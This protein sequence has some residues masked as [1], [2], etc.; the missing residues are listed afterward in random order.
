MEGQKVEGGLGG[1]R[2]GWVNGRTD[3]GMNQRKDGRMLER[4]RDEEMNGWMEGVN[5]GKAIHH[6]NN[7]G[8]TANT[9]HALG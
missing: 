5:G 7:T 1:S 3:G 9:L 6:P 8:V 2:D 4:G